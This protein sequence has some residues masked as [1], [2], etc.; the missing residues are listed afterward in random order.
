MS[1]EVSTTRFVE[2]LS[3][4]GLIAT[5]RLTTVLS[6]LGY[7]EGGSTF[8]SA[9]DLAARLV[10]QGILTQFQ[11]SKLLAGRY[12][13]LVMGP[14]R[15]LT[16]LGKGGMG[17]VYLAQDSRRIGSTT[18][19]APGLRCDYH[20]ESLVALK[21]LP[22]R[23]A[24]EEPRMVQRLERE[25][26]YYRRVD[27]PQIVRLEEAGEWQGVRYLA[28]EFVPGRSLQEVVARWGRLDA[29]RALRLFADVAAG[30]H[31]MHQRKLVHRDIK[32]ANIMVTPEGGGKILDL[33]LALALDE[34]PPPDIRIAGGKGY[35][36]G[37]MDYIAPEQARHAT[38][39]DHRADLYALGCTLY[40]ALTGTPPFPGGSKKDK[41]RWQRK[42]EPLPVRQLNPAVPAP[43]AELIHRLMAKRPQERPES[44]EQVRRELL[45]MT[46]GDRPISLMVAC[47][48]QETVALY[49][50][51][52]T[53][54]DWWSEASGET[55]ALRTAG[56]LGHDRLDPAF[57]PPLPPATS[58]PRQPLSPLLAS[59]WAAFV[60]VGGLVLVVMLLLAFRSL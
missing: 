20:W 9:R 30:L 3:Y 23:L 50:T 57:P 7:A 32:P 55:G 29:E 58:A 25:E 17:L 18:T 39:I 34:I 47:S 46:R 24:R 19:V 8:T 13:G 41:I 60:L 45:S 38:A 15:L 42:V 49:D 10:E 26:R 28:L 37:T 2:L 44:A 33:G 54:T 16:P 43:L 27:H 40:F 12:V 4:S 36:V 35:I 59:V 48:A 52:T 6:E 1:S 31:H 51:D 22:P 11:A 21:V 53:G 14:Y 56:F 5:E